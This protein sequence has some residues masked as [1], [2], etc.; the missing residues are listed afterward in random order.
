[1][2]KYK[3]MLSYGEVSTIHEALL[4]LSYYLKDECEKVDHPEFYEES[5]CY[6]LLNDFQD[7]LEEYE[8]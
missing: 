1:M 5:V 7:W 3:F 6:H 8:K 2:G 4:L